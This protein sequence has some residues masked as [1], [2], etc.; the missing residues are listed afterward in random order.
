MPAPSASRRAAAVAVAGLA[1]LALTTLAAA[2]ASAHGSMGDPVSRVSQC[3]AEG[4]EN[5]KSAA[6]RAAVAAGGTQA[7][8]DWN[9]I[10]IGNAAGKH[11][12]L[13]PDGR[14]CSANDP[15]FKGLDLARADWPATG[16]SSGSYTFKY[17]VTAPHKGT[18]KVYLTKPG[19]D[20]S[21]PLGW[22]DLDLSAPVATSTDPVAS[23]G[24][25]TFSGTLPERSGKHL[26]YAVWQRSDS[27]EAF[28]SCS[29]VTFG[30]DGDGDGDGGSGSGAATGDDTASGDAEAGA[31]PAP[32][33]SA[34]SEEQLAAAAEKSTIE[35]HGHGDQDAATTTDPTDPAAA[36]EEAPGTAAEPHQVKAAGG[37]TENLAETGGDSTTPYIAVGGAAALA[38]GAA[39]L[40]ASVRRR[41]TTGGRHGH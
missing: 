37:G 27:P 31:A 5:P 25:Y 36:P 4:P 11:Q 30:G 38:L 17:R 29:D 23:G 33:A 15:A 1:P 16:V 9:G 21:K 18:F 7:L 41:A 14:L 28:Y 35:H 22:G 2:P 10:R 3:H 24:F 34:P 19:Y 13:I 40:F 20:P 12:E 8:Y 32:E 39:V 26:L 6:C